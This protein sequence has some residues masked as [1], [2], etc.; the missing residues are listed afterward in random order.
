MGARETGKRWWTWCLRVALSTLPHINPHRN[1]KVAL[2]LLGK[3]FDGVRGCDYFNADR[4]C[5]GWWSVM[6][7]FYPAHLIHDVKSLTTLP[8]RCDRAYG[9]RLR[10]ALEE[11]FAVFHCREKSS[12][13]E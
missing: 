6:V 9:K 11:L 3:E 2:D 13:R 4:G 10:V 5:L 7:Q 1:A 8:D 12:L